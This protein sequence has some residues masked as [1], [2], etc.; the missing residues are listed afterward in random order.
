MYVSLRLYD[1]RTQN[2]VY[3]LIDMDGQAVKGGRWFMEKDLSKN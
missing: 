1:E 3:Q 2:W